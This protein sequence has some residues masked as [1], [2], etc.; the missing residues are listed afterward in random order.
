MSGNFS[1]FYFTLKPIG[2][3]YYTSAYCNT[4]YKTKFN[5]LVVSSVSFLIYLFFLLNILFD[6]GNTLLTDPSLKSHKFITD[7][8]C[9]RYN[10]WFGYFSHILIRR[11][12]NRNWHKNTTRNRWVFLVKFQD[13]Y[14]GRRIGRHPN[15]TKIILDFHLVR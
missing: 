11:M 6:I 7:S 1:I 9:G 4:S 3:S 15:V 8:L 12:Q 2:I 14:T 5:C 13:T 10:F